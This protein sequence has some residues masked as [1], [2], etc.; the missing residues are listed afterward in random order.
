MLNKKN[1]A[2]KIELLMEILEKKSV[3]KIYHQIYIIDVQK[4][5]KE[6][7]IM[8]EIY[9]ITKIIIKFTIVNILE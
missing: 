3:I 6:I 1:L 4:I 8:I 9:K 7:F 5:K 2:T